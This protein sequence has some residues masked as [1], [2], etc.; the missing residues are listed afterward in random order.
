LRDKKATSYKPREKRQ[1][2]KEEIKHQD[3][4]AGEAPTNAPPHKAISI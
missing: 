1:E 3:N 2:T 4:G